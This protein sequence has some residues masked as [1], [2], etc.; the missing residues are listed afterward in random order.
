MVKKKELILCECHWRSDQP[1]WVYLSTVSSRAEV[2]NHK[3]CW[4]HIQQ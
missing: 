4:P 1:I 2:T 3:L